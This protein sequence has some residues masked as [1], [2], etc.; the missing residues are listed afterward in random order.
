MR[1]NKLFIMR[2][3]Y[4]L[5]FSLCMGNC[6]TAENSDAEALKQLNGRPNFHTPIEFECIEFAVGYIEAGSLGSI[7]EEISYYSN[8][9]DFYGK[10][11]KNL[12]FIRADIQKERNKWRVRKY[13]VKDIKTVRYNK[14]TGLVILTFDYFLS[15]G[16]KSLKGTGGSKII[17]NFKND[18][19]K[20]IKVSDY[21]L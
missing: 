10:G 4:L 11:M 7:D 12:K 21:K 17:I 18:T 15:N 16:R 3:F 6:Q 8:E 20:V 19:Q 13:E 9:V 2:T 5:L 1:T 14:G